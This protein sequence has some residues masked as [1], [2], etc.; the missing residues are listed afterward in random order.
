MGPRKDLI[1]AHLRVKKTNPKKPNTVTDARMGLAS[2][3]RDIVT[4]NPEDVFD[5]AG[6]DAIKYKDLGIHDSWA[7]KDPGLIET[8]WGTPLGHSEK[9]MFR[10]GTRFINTKDGIVDMADT[11]KSQ[12]F[13][14]G[15]EINFPQEKHG[16]DQHLKDLEEFEPA[17]KE[18]ITKA[19][20]LSQDIQ[21]EHNTRSPIFDEGGWNTDPKFQQLK[22]EPTVQDYQPEG[23]YMDPNELAKLKASWFYE[24]PL[25]K[26]LSPPKYKPPPVDEFYDKTPE[27]KDQLSGL[28]P[29]HLKNYQY[30]SVNSK[31]GKVSGH[32]PA[33]AIGNKSIPEGH[34]VFNS[35]EYSMYNAPKNQTP[36]VFDEHEVNLPDLGSF[37][38][39]K[40]RHNLEFEP[41]HH[42]L[43]DFDEWHLNMLKEN[44]Q[45]YV[46]T[47]KNGSLVST[48]DD[49]KPGWLLN[50]DRSWKNPFFSGK[51]RF[52]KW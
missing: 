27:F 19:K 20:E 18:A 3:L 46:Y 36:I 5:K 25:D 40:K 48:G 7:V 16:F 21:R 1:E 11:N 39:Q 42:P 4:A 49:I 15:D 51:N 12:Y 22:F 30:I 23:D 35:P 33:G 31:T 34:Y 50:S 10:R 28:D 43:T 52:V 17:K 37:L 24:P 2:R 8:P 41:K 38:G 44:N 6:F 14:V 29:E 32:Y 45:P 9:K 26:P 13:N 47:A